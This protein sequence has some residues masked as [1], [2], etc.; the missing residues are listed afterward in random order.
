M[1]LTTEKIKEKYGYDNKMLLLHYAGTSGEIPID[2]IREINIS[3]DLQ[4]YIVNKGPFSDFFIY[5]RNA[6]LKGY[7]LLGK[8]LS[9][10]LQDKYYANYKPYVTDLSG[11]LR[12]TTS[13]ISKRKRYRKTA[14][15]YHLLDVLDISYFPILKKDNNFFYP[16][17]C[18]KKIFSEEVKQYGIEKKE[19]Y[20]I[21][22]SRIFGMLQADGYLYNTYVFD[23]EMCNLNYSIELRTQILTNTRFKNIDKLSDNDIETIIITSDIEKQKEIFIE[24]LE[25]KTTDNKKYKEKQYT[26]YRQMDFEGLHI[27]S[28]DNIGKKQLYILKHRNY[29]DN[30]IRRRIG[31]KNEH[32]CL[33]NDS[34]NC[35]ARILETPC[36]FLY[37]LDITK[38]YYIYNVLHIQNNVFCYIVCFKEHIPMLK[39]ILNDVIEYVK[40]ISIEQLNLL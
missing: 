14:K 10:L 32:Q 34:I 16:A 4:N 2:L 36:V 11:L 22:G 5:K 33:E 12:R 15:L 25:S 39:K 35:D 37:S 27:L 40:F 20:E 13:D 21:K 24:L 38:I 17:H 31:S 28:F 26:I 8:G 1:F 7:Q 3:S 19:E 30:E 29:I 9:F 6:G 23:N 18:I